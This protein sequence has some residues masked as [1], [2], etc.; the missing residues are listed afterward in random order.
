MPKTPASTP[1]FT[2]SFLRVTKRPAL[3]NPLL[4]IGLPGVGFVSKLAVDHLVREKGAERIATLYSPHFPN[5]VLSMKSGRLRLFSIGFYVKRFKKRDVLFMRGDLQ[6]LTVE[7]QFEVSAKALDFARQLG[8]IETIAMAGYA[9]QG[10]KDKP[11]IFASATNREFFKKI[12][13]LGAQS[14]EQVVPIVGMAGLV[15]ALAKLYGMKGC[16]LLVE[17]QGTAMDVT[18]AKALLELI[19]KIVGEK[20]SYKKLEERVSKV[21]KMFKKMEGQGQPMPAVQ[22]PGMP[23]AVEKDVLRYIR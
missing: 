23:E 15:P 19:S 20:F 12:T 9:T 2:E 6:P 4:L 17:T 16:C 22:P 13:A 21:E 18:G 1:T 11:K 5:Q 10:K 8:C 3:K 14:S 7:G